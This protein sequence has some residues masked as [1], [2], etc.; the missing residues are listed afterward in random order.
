MSESPP[1]PPPAA[2]VFEYLWLACLAL[3]GLTLPQAPPLLVAT[4]LASRSDSGASWVAPTVSE[5]SEARGDRTHTKG[6]GVQFHKSSLS[7]RSQR[8][9]GSGGGGAPAIAGGWR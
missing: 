4:Q 9:L 1:L 6:P 7:N 2:A 5:D 8:S 3:T